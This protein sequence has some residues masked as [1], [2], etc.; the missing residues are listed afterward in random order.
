MIVYRVSEQLS[1]FIKIKVDNL[2]MLKIKVSIDPLLKMKKLRYSGINIKNFYES[3]K[4][5]RPFP[6]EER[7][8]KNRQ[9]F[10]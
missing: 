9:L 1:T 6:I 2:L 4:R 8:F 7:A 10:G 3:K 5:K